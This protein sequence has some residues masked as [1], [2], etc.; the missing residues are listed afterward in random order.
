MNGLQSTKKIYI[1]SYIIQHKVLFKTTYAHLVGTPSIVISIRHKTME[2]VVIVCHYHLYTLPLK[3][4]LICPHFPNYL[5]FFTLLFTHPCTGIFSAYLICT[6]WLVIIYVLSRTCMLSLTPLS[7]E[8]C[9]HIYNVYCLLFCCNAQ[10][11]L[12]VFYYSYKRAVLKSKIGKTR[13]SP[14]TT[15]YIHPL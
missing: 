12:L 6:N 13:M 14:S 1:C 4:P 10:V 11:I 7:Y 8:I 5:K 2:L 15:T 9:M 3:I